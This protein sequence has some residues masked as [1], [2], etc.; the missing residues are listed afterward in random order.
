MVREFHDRDPLKLVLI[1]RAQNVG[2]RF[3][4]TITSQEQ[5]KEPLIDANDQTSI[6]AVNK[7]SIADWVD[8]PPHSI[9][10]QVRITTRGC[11]N[12]RPQR[13]RRVER[14]RGGSRAL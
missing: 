10:K 12:R 11:L 7:V 13:P 5:R 9:S 2:A 1:C 8:H 3:A 14:T 4:R 6:I